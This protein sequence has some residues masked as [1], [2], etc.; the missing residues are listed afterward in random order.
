M[1]LANVE[2]L[3]YSI[4]S[5]SHEAPRN[6]SQP[7]VSSLMSKGTH[8]T[9]ITDSTP[10]SDLVTQRLLDGTSTR[11]AQW[12]LH[13]RTPRLLVASFL[14]GLSATFSQHF[15]YSFLHHKSEDRENTKTSLVLVGR[16]LAYI[17]KV[18]FAQCIIM[19]YR[20]RI[21]RT[22]R[23]RALSVRSIDQLFSGIE[24]ASLLINWE[25]VSNAPVV[26][27][28]ALVV[29]LLPLATVIASPSALTFAWRPEV[30]DAFVS[31]PILNFS[32]ES[33]KDWRNPV[34]AYDGSNKRSIIYYNTTDYAAKEPGWFDYYDQPSA[35][36]ENIL[37]K[38]IFS[39]PMDVL[40]S[41]FNQEIARQ[42]SCGG[43]FNCTY[44][45]SFLAP[46]YK[47]E[48][49][50]SRPDGLF[51]TSVLVPEGDHLYYADVDTGDYAR[52]Q[53][54][55]FKPG[56]GGVPEGEIPDHAGD[57]RFEPELWI[58]Y[59]FNTTERLPEDSPFVANWT[60]RYEQHIM[61]CILHE[62]NYT[63]DFN[64]TGHTCQITQSAQYVTPL[65]GYNFSQ[66]T[67]SILPMDKWLS[68]RDNT[69]TYKKT[70]AYHAI[71][72]VFRKVLRGKITAHPVLPGPFYAQVSSDISKTSLIQKN[73]EA[74]HNISQRL[75]DLFQG[76]VT[77]YLAAPQML[78]NSEQEILVHRSRFRVA[79]V[80][81]S[82]R[83]WICYGPVLLFTLAIL[84]VGAWTIWEDGTTFS[85]GFSRVLA[86]T[87]NPTLD[88]ISRGACLGN[89]PFPAQLMQRKLQFGALQ[90]D[91][92]LGDGSDGFAGC[93][94]VGHCAF[95]VPGEVGPI[96]REVLYTGL[97]MAAD[98]MRRKKKVKVE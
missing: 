20:Q 97:G 87:R 75:E 86:T 49:V 69:A 85:T 67:E 14:I 90:D 70:A 2:E 50:T 72:E 4:K 63:V 46:G 60:H 32:I 37:W 52:P 66:R 57:L 82:V 83:F 81:D 54:E 93:E 11:P 73:S 6:Q 13:W 9:H 89:D 21:W 65:H 58:G 98:V 96:R 34:K 12:R 35:E 41:T 8:S 80:Y 7:D 43:N 77:S 79:F 88:G 71:G 36:T 29:W 55:N 3:Q 92:S 10:M 15:L 84:L 51:N 23:N 1:V 44:S 25:A 62:T 17:A 47:C 39:S 42:R 33:Y 5:T 61:R 64:F 22:F 59:A 48:D 31:V 53:F 30:G 24:D 28:M 16:A 19:C 78:V 94:S 27:G 76:L 74:Q 95:G 56:V 18:A 40:N 26:A 91:T 38:N 45:I 68:P